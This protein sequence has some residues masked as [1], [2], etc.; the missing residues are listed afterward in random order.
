MTISAI[1]RTPI[2]IWRLI[3]H[4]AIASPLLPFVED[5]VLSTHLI[6][7]L[8]LFSATCLH[9]FI[10]RDVTQATIERLR[11]VCRTWAD[12]LR[13]N[14][15]DFAITDLDSHHYT[16]KEM[17]KR[18]RRV[19]IWS[20]RM[21]G[22]I[23]YF[24]D[25][26]CP[27]RHE[28]WNIRWAVE[29]SAEQY[30]NNLIP[31]VNILG[32]DPLLTSSLRFLVPLSNLVALSLNCGSPP[33]G[34]WSMRELT[35]CA[36]RLTHLD[37]TH[38]RENSRLLSENITYFNLLYLRLE[39]FYHEETLSPQNFMNWTFPCLQTLIIRGALDPLCEDF[40]NT[41]ITRH[42]R[43][44][45]GLDIDYHF[46]DKASLV[47]TPGHIPSIL[48]DI[49]PEINAFGISSYHIFK[50][51]DFLKE[52]RKN[53][54]SSIQLLIHDYD[55]EFTPLSKLVGLLQGLVEIWNVSKVII[56]EPWND[57]SNIQS[58]APILLT[59]L[60]LSRSH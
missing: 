7:T 54:Y 20:G 15:C 29:M 47:Y 49:C 21:C 26:A 52:A 45:I 4:H 41:F 14:T 34:V 36:P 5:G 51:I 11:L 48:W 46:C 13:N 31:N 18:A 56:A 55:T 32:L 22:P 39:L 42:A 10:Y 8:N 35:I 6:E 50:N 44:L 38:L 33:E 2:E 57:V 24:G 43:G 28:S 12:L 25:I 53:K 40:V 27:F 23:E 19:D 17:N 30:L 1:E 59:D 60:T 58:H 3:L 9:C 37:L 16:S